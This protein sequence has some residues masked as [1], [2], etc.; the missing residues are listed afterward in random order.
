MHLWK[1]VLMSPALLCGLGATT[2]LA[3]EQS[4][5]TGRTAAAARAVMHYMESE[6]G[7]S[8]LSTTQEPWR[9]TIAS[10]DSADWRVIFDRLRIMLHA[11]VPVPGDPFIHYLEVAETR[12]SDTASMFDINVGVESRC[13]GRSGGSVIG[14][15]STT[16]PVS[17]TGATW[18]WHSNGPPIDVEPGVCPP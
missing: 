2:S 12:I 10:P 1:Q 17:R 3:Q 7:Q 5:Q 9:F 4:P 16:V 13:T 14:G 18:D 15:I 11:R 6:L 8:R